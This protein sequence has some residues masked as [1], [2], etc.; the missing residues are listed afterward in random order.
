MM[1]GR[2]EKLFSAWIILFV[3]MGCAITRNN[4]HEMDFAKLDKTKVSSLTE[5]QLKLISSEAK[6]SVIFVNNPHCFGDAHKIALYANNKLIYLGGYAKQF[7]A[8]LWDENKENK[9]VHFSIELI[10]PGAEKPSYSIQDKSVILW[11]DDYKYLYIGFFPNNNDPD[12]I[13]FFPQ[14]NEVIQ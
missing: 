3:L 14:K 8:S 4:C 12:K 6:I 7:K 11:D 13:H 5:L 9:P 10:E 2:F 1:I